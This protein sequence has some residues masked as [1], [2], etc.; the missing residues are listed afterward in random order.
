MPFKLDHVT[1]AATNLDTLVE[2]FSAAGMTLDYGGA[3]SN[4]ITH[5]SLLGFSDGSYIELIST[6]TPGVPAPDGVNTSRATVVRVPGP[7]RSVTFPRTRRDSRMQVF[8]STAR[9]MSTG[10]DP[11]G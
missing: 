9:P 5:M 3:H 6:V 4:G 2:G 11:M 7:S 8:Q 1:L 10:N